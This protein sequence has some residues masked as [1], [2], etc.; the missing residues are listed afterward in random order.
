MKNVLLAAIAVAGLAA[1]A[2]AQSWAE[3]GDAP[4]LGGQTTVGAGV[5]NVIT[6]GLTGNA[7]GLSDFEDLYIIRIADPLNFRATTT[8]GSTF[9]T[10]LFLFDAAGNGIAF[11]DD[12][13]GLQST[14]T[15][16]F[17]S[18]LPAGLY[19]LAVSG[20]DRDGVDANGLEIFADTPF[21][22]E[23]GPTVGRG[24]LA[25]WSGSNSSIGTYTITLQGV[26]FAQ[27]V[28]TPGSAALA[29]L[30]CLAVAK[31]R[32]RA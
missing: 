26:E 19:L 1:A 9:D 14:L 5:L 11:N 22:S 31:R 8:V 18:A 3:T 17:T 12:S 16:A 15:N 27:A 29:G 7:G 30:G 24:P 13:T 28:P 6:G 21:A 32:R 23:R 4:A 25:G 10:Q 20:Y 2:N